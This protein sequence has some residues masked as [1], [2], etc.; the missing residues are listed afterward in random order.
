MKTVCDKFGALF[1]LDE[2][3]GY[4][5]LLF[6][7]NFLLSGYFLLGYEW[8]GSCVSYTGCFLYHL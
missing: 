6:S 3:G 1:I 7:P 2:V 8:H 4:L 5:L